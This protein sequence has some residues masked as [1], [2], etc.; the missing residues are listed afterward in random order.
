MKIR[1]VKRA[2]VWQNAGTVIDAAPADANFLLA[3]GSAE[4]VMDPQKPE[5]PEAKPQREKRTK[6]G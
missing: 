1:L 2:K 3:V 6:K 4:L 5:T